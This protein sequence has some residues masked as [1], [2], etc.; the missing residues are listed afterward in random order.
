MNILSLVATFLS[1][2]I[3][4]EQK[5][6]SNSIDSSFLFLLEELYVDNVVLGLDPNLDLILHCPP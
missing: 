6:T 4:N 5:L 2:I 1:V 3:A